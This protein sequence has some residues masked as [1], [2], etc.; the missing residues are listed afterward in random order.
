MTPEPNDFLHLLSAAEP[1]GDA[2]LT[3]PAPADSGFTCDDEGDDGAPVG[4]GEGPVGV[5]TTADRPISS[6]LQG[7][8]QVA[9]LHDARLHPAE[10]E[11]I[12]RQLRSVHTVRDA[13]GYLTQVLARL[14]AAGLRTDIAAP[15]PRPD[16]R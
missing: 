4:P 14:D 1:R 15:S 6:T 3:L 5:R 9:A 10:R 13:H 2:P 11:R 8:L 7:F 12:V 16:G